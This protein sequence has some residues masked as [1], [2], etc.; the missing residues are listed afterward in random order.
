MSLPQRQATA[1]SQKPMWKTKRNLKNSPIKAVKQLFK[2]VNHNIC[3][4]IC[5]KV[6]T[7]DYCREI[8]DVNQNRLS[9]IA[10]EITNE[11]QILAIKVLFYAHKCTCSIAAPPRIKQ[12]E[13]YFQPRE[14]RKEPRP[15]MK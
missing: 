6:P 12:E 1:R 2:E 15:W 11:K 14:D 13:R 3:G 9:R 5:V 7:P 4:A 10:L 8:N